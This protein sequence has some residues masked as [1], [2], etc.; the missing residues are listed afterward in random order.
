MSLMDLL[1]HLHSIPIK[2]VFDHLGTVI[3]EICFSANM[4][5]HVISEWS[6]AISRARIGEYVSN[7][8]QAIPQLHDHMSFG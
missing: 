2:K 3:A 4:L 1:I 8:E 7:Y 6:H 5:T